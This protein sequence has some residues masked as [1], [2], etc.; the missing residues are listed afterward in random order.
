MVLL[1][2]LMVAIP[3]VVGQNCTLAYEKWDDEGIMISSTLGVFVSYGRPRFR[4]FYL[5][6]I[7]M[8]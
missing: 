1:S 3:P 2:K 6:Y 4:A 7:L 5:V 8:L